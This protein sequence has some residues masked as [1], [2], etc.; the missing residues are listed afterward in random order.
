MPAHLVLTPDQLELVE[1]YVS[2]FRAVGIHLD[3]KAVWPARAFGAR[4]GS[5]H[6]WAKL[7]LQAQCKLHLRIRHFVTWLIV[8]QRVATSAAYIVVGRP[9]LGDVALRRHPVFGNA[10]LDTAV[11]LGFARATAMAQWSDVAKLAGLYQVRPEQLSR[12]QFDAGYA[13]LIDAAHT[14]R[15]Q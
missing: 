3:D 8:T 14:H 13:A 12:T 6:D 15:P 10:F 4:V 7:S 5:P 1:A 9:F 2:S 11:S